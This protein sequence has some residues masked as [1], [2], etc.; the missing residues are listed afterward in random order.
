MRFK[1]LLVYSVKLRLWLNDQGWAPCDGLT[2]R[3]LFE[4]LLHIVPAISSMFLAG[5]K[6]LFS[7]VLI[8][9]FWSHA[10]LCIEL[11]SILHVSDLPDT[12]Y[13]SVV[14]L[15]SGLR[16][17][18]CLTLLMPGGFPAFL[19]YWSWRTSHLPW[20]VTYPGSWRVLLL[21]RGGELVLSGH[22]KSC[23]CS[24]GLVPYSGCKLFFHG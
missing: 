6:R 24:T 5:S 14:S 2:F 3:P 13:W 15:I 23:D 1:F 17:L 16:F 20:S 22:N 4:Y 21:M 8:Y 19:G 10:E 11:F 12:L 18:S 7:V 9:G